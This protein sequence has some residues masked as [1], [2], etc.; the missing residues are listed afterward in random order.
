VGPLA[1]AVLKE[2]FRYLGVRYSWGGNGLKG[3]D[4]SGLVRNVFG[5]CG[6]RLPRTASQQA[7]VG[8]LVALN[9]PH[10]LCPGDR[11]YF[12]VKRKSID[13]T[14]IYIGNGYFIHAAMSRGEVGV[15]RLSTPLYGR[16]LVQVMR[17]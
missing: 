13:H 11:L 5:R 8:T 9:G 6:F 17:F 10:S 1:A 12:S 2:A 3:I 7:R 14:G 16:N 4:C 15:D